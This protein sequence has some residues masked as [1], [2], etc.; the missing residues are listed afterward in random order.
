[1]AET[2]IV[3]AKMEHIPDPDLIISVDSDKDGTPQ[4]PQLDGNFNDLLLPIPPNLDAEQR[5]FWNWF[6]T[7][8]TQVG[9]LRRRI[10]LLRRDWYHP[11]SN[12]RY[13]TIVRLSEHLKQEPERVKQLLEDES[14]FLAYAAAL[15]LQGA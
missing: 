9:E 5:A 2:L 10:G 1:M 8:T 14:A 11:L 4:N 6:P 15:R 3:D 7:K 13:H 12:P